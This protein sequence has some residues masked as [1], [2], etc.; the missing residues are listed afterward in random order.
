M[1]YYK[2]LLY[3]YNKIYNIFNI[4]LYIKVFIEGSY[5]SI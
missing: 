5:L 2:Y 3:I 1:M 4:L